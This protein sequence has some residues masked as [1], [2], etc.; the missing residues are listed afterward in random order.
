MIVRSFLKWYQT[1]PV[2]DRVEAV[3]AMAQAYLSEQLGADDPAEAEAALTLVLDDPA[4]SVRRALAWKLALSERAPRHLLIGLAHDR[5][6]VSSLILARSPQLRDADLIDCARTGQALSHLA[7]AMRFTLS[8]AVCA[9]LAEVAGGDA[10]VALCRNPGADIP[11]D[12]FGVMVRRHPDHG[13]LRE[14]LAE[15][16]DLPTVV[17]QSL[18][19]SLSNQLLA[20]VGRT[21]M[22]ESGRA[23][24]LIGDSRELATLRLAF[25]AAD[26]GAFVEH[27]R[28]TAQLTPSLLLRGVLSS[29][30]TLLGAAL[31]SLT[32]TAPRRV[33]GILKGRGPAFR[34]LYARAGLPHH[35]CAAFD[36]ALGVIHATKQRDA[37]Q[38]PVLNRSIIQTVL[39]ACL[40]GDE[41]VMR[42]V[43][44]L[45]RR[46][47]AE[48]AREDARRLTA[49][50]LRE[51]APAIIASG[52]I[53]AD[54]VLALP[55][56]DLDAFEHEIMEELSIEHAL[57]AVGDEPDLAADPVEADMVEPV[58]DPVS[59]LPAAP[60]Q[61][62]FHYEVPVVYIPE[63]APEIAAPVEPVVEEPVVAELDADDPLIAEDNLRYHDELDTLF[64]SA[65]GT[66]TPAPS[67]GALRVVESLDDQLDESYFN[68]W[69]IRRNAA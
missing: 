60:A 35:L 20:F 34:A 51:E 24:R 21:G 59:E 10:L 27:L 13:A 22:I 6:E 2:S 44:A 38:E 25:E 8:E 15:R 42:P 31:V 58:F 50:L 36:A 65:F 45:L 55:M 57:D 29:D 7:I 67:T 39:A 32:G 41:A 37:M 14:A 52:E 69:D 9:V 68:S 23:E 28:E 16:D 43:L 17:R 30:D 18:V 62:T 19:A 3:E 47:D 56:I 4:A 11:A 40:G 26:L 64:A 63:V 5:A 49:S 66:D 33:A 61:P 12:S 54:E 53:D 1:A 46:F 48:A